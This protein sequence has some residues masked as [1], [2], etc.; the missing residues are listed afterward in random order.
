MHWEVQVIFISQ[1]GTERTDIAITNTGSN[2]S[3]FDWHIY[4]RHDLAQSK[5]KG[6]GNAH[7]DCE[8]LAN[9]DRRGKQ[10]YFQQIESL[11]V[12]FPFAYLHLTLVQSKC[13]GQGQ[14]HFDCEHL[15]TGER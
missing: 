10:C 2:M 11:I 5:G 1:A 9:S 12:S 6:R 14:A 4:I 7:F 8:Y 13:K 3:S 15:A